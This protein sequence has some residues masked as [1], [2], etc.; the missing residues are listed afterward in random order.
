M[1]VTRQQYS[2]GPI[3]ME[4]YQ[5][6]M[7]VTF[8]DHGRERAGAGDGKAEYITVQIRDGRVWYFFS[9]FFFFLA[10]EG[11]QNDGELIDD[12]QI[13]FLGWLSTREYRRAIPSFHYWG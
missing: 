1:L 6:R 4:Q 2:G 3:E 8:V 10:A 7:R 11:F 9:C 13:A 12:V 5:E